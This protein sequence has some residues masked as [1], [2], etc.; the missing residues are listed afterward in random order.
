[1]IGPP[2]WPFRI[3]KLICRDDMIEILYGDVIEIYQ[4]RAKKRGRRIANVLF[5][6]DVLS[7]I[8]P[9]AMKQPYRVN[10]ATGA[11][12]LFKS[13]FKLSFRNFLRNRMSSGINLFGLII[14]LFVPLM[15][16]QYALFEL[17]YDQFHTNYD[18]IYRVS[19]QREMENE[20]VFDGATTFLPVGPLMMDEYPEVLNQC[21]FYYPFTHGMVNY[22]DEAYHL[23][24]PFFVEQSYFELFDFQLLS[25]DRSSVLSEPNTV[26]LSE[27]LARKYFGDKEPIGERIKFSFEDGEAD[28]VVKGI[29]EN[30]RMDSH[31]RLDI[32]ISFSTLNQWEIFQQSDWSLPFYHTYIQLMDGT[33]VDEFEQKVNEILLRS[34]SEAA[35]RGTL[36]SFRLQPLQGIHLDSDLTFE[37]EQNGNRQAVNFLVLIASMILLLAYLNYINLTTAFASI[38]AKEVGIRKVM[39]SFRNQLISQ[40]LTESFIVNFIGLSLAVLSVYLLARPF[41]SLL[42]IYFEFSTDGT[43][44]LAILAIVALGAI[45]SGIYPAW[46]LS[47]YQPIT[48]LKGKFI[49][50]KKGSLLRKVLVG[51]QFI[52]SI[53]IIG[54]TILVRQ[55]TDFLLNKDLGFEDEKMLVVNS[56]RVMDPESYLSR[57]RGF[58]NEI[59]SL[60]D[61]NGFTHSGS[62]PGKVMS[63]GS[64]T[65]ADKQGSEPVSMHIVTVDYDYFKTYDLRILSGRAFS[66]DFPSDQMGAVLNEAAVQALGFEDYEAAIKGKIGLGERQFNIVGVVK[67]Y[68]HQSLRND[69]DPIVFAFLPQRTVY[70]S[71]NIETGDLPQTLKSIEEKMLSYFPGNSFEY[72][73]LDQAFDQEFKAELKYAALLAGFS[74]LAILLAALGLF[75]LASFIVMQRAKELAVRKVMGARGWDVFAYLTFSFLWPMLIGCFIAWFGLYFAGNSWLQNFPFRI[76][77]SWI[78]FGLPV[79]IVVGMTCLTLGIQT[80]KASRIKPAL[81]LR[82]E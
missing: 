4:S 5:V 12:T 10:R 46:V 24:K 6:I 14:G 13:Y 67:N 58:G 20:V 15:I 36:E 27:D 78:I 34:R 64:F 69:Y 49:T 50:S 26:V 16:A 82:N 72:H 63:A 37:M 18:Q 54:G 33:S 1:M 62:V 47:G 59:K 28:L 40:F 71:M 68:N 21:R 75:G 48:V 55:Q 60:P 80:I 7:L 65:N 19:F 77:L 51:A 8:K 9:F 74:V 25:G 66:R 29:L 11:L 2:K 23:E 31:I 30:P 70:W 22:G 3:L 79:G 81:A 38:R 61:I 39:G 73:F 32:L 53:I 56:P 42:G 57:V 76:G 41:S 52:I 45:L 17:R 44:W 43:F 35:A